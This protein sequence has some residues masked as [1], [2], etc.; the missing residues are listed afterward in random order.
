MGRTDQ[1][2]SEAGDP[3]HAR[4]TSR[5]DGGLLILTGRRSRESVS[6]GANGRA[7]ARAL[8][9]RERTVAFAAGKGVVGGRSI[10]SG[11]SRLPSGFDGISSG[12]DREPEDRGHTNAGVRAHHAAVDSPAHPASVPRFPG[13][14]S[15][16]ELRQGVVGI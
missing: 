4:V 7:T 16:R 5:N 8:S 3:R 11:L 10:G 15:A 9:H 2:G 6:S 1:G 13:A 14:S 12:Q